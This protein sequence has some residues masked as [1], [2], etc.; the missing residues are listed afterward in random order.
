MTQPH[1]G[2]CFRFIETY[3]TL[4]NSSKGSEIKHQA[5]PGGYRDHITDVMRIAVVTYRAQLSIRELPFSLSDALVGCFLH[6]VEKLWKHALDPGHKRDIDKEDLLDGHFTMDD[7]L[8]NSIKYAHGEG[9]DYHPT[10]RIQCPLA[11][12][13]HHCDNTS[14]R[15]WFDKPEP[16]NRSV[17]D[18]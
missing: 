9:D 10:D 3:K 2:E 14:A 6:D 8:W 12:F 7:D 13:V 5:W 17:V 1:Q 11:A 18:D 4:F 15:I 16:K